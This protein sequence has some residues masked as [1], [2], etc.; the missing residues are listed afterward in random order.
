MELLQRL[1]LSD[2]PTSLIRHD[3]DLSHGTVPQVVQ[4]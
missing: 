2:S 3:P 1:C 4:R